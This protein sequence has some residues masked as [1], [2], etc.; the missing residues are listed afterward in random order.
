MAEPINVVV[1]TSHPD[2]VVNL[3]KAKDDGIIGVIQKAAQGRTF[4][5]PTF[6]NNR[7]KYQNANPLWGAYHFGI[8][9]DGVKRAEH[10]LKA[11]KPK[12]DTCWFSTL[13]ATG[14]VPTCR[15]KR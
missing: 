7:L 3:N 8:G 9:G 11:V 14:R 6:K 15:W 1:D 12:S 10:F 4:I 13:R 5:D 2:G